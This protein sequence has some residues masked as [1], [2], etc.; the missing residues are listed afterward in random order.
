MLCA[1]R[2]AAAEDAGTLCLRPL[3]VAQ[4]FVVLG[5]AGERLLRQYLY[6]CTSKA[7]K[8]VAQD[9]AVLGSAGERAFCVSICTFVL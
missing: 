3:Y 2:P 6:F 1:S 8:A 4:D 5:R 7:S 9:F